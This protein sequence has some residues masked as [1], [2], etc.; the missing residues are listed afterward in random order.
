MTE[1]S[2]ARAAPI[3]TGA[4]S[5]S[6]KLTGP[7]VRAWPAV[8]GVVG[9]LT[10]ILLG[11]V[12]GPARLPVFG[13]AKELLGLR[14]NL[15]TGASIVWQIR[16]PR[17]IL[18]V[19]VGGVLSVAGGAYQGA[20]RNPLADPYLL[21]VAS[22]GGLGATLAIVSSAGRGFVAPAAFVGS[23]LA[24][25][26][27]YLLGSNDRLRSPATLILAGVA[28]SSLFTAVQTFV[29][30]RNTDDIRQI[31]GWI[32]G[33]LS[34]SGWTDVLTLL[35]YAVVCTVLLVLLAR[36]LDVLAVG[37]VETQSLGLSPVRTR[38]AIVVVASLATAAAVSVS[39]LIVFVG[40]IVPHTVRLVAGHS[41][42]TIL[43]LSFLYGGVFLAL[44]DLAGRTV[45][46]PAEVPISVVTAFF[47]APFFL[48]ILR[49]S[50]RAP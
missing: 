3:S 5:Q 46:S 8:G 34:T 35:P 28:V 14:S 43:P 25:A 47:G 32:L 16:L 12:I 17:V 13:V 40:I 19:M 1:T 31:Y 9:V 20:F 7:R 15:G 4:R 45:F 41:Y 38:L 33:R 50:R 49:S 11:V 18:A 29:Q 23:L 42:R 36:R 39:G 22:G 10:V 44:C 6:I 27:T 21:G 2:V 26:L 48:L 30:Q 24:V 37:D